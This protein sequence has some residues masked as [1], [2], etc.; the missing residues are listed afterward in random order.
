MPAWKNITLDIPKGDL[1]SIS[2]KISHIKRVLSINIT[3]KIDEPNSKWFDEGGKQQPLLGETH[4]IKL[5]TS[6]SINSE[7]L[8]N[9]IRKK[10]EDETI[11]ILKEEIFEDR[12]WI[13]HS[14]NQFRE[15][16]ITDTLRILPPWVAD[17]NKNGTSI[18]IDP[19][20]GFGTGSHPTTQLCLKWIEKNNDPNSSLFDYGCGSGILSIA[21]D[22]FGYNRVVGVDNDHEAL[23]N[24]ERNKDLNSSDIVFFHSDD[25]NENESYDITVANI[26][27]NTIISLR[28]TLISSLKENG[29]LILSGIL[30]EQAS[31]I[32]DA[33]KSDM[34][35][36]I[37]DQQEG[38][39]LMKGKKINSN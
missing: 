27:L 34:F 6:A 17:K 2:E 29:I 36:S 31:D 23:V 15:I 22:K 33:F 1:N 9:D 26:L 3:D 21:A 37:V 10:L 30:E 14:K 38:W 16:K 19:G 32:I 4:L 28:E 24:A 20:S 13:Q 18:I 12:D 25:V 7:L 35:L 39:L 5:L 11:N 8:N